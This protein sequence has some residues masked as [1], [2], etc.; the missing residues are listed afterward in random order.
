MAR[1][2]EEARRL[3]AD[4]STDWGTLYELAQTN[5]EV[6]AEIAANPSTYPDLLAWL[7]SLG[8]PDVDAALARRAAGSGDTG[9][10]DEPEP[11]AEPEHQPEPESDLADTAATPVVREPEPESEPEPEPE[12]KPEPELAATVTSPAVREPEPASETQVLP[13]SEEPGAPPAYA[14]A[15]AAAAARVPLTVERVP[16]AQTFGRQPAAPGPGQ[17]PLEPEPPAGEDGS[18]RRL[19]LILVVIGVLA[20]AGIAWLFGR[21]GDEPATTPT[22]TPTVAPTTP[23]PTD[24]GPTSDAQAALDAATA[25]LASVFAASQCT[26]PEADGAALASWAEARLGVGAWDAAAT[27]S[28]TS[29]ITSLQSRCNAGHAVAVADRAG[30]QAPDLAAALGDREWVVPTLPAPADAADITA[31]SSPSGNI[32]C[33]LGEDSVTCS[34]QQYSFGSPGACP[35]PD[36]PV[37]VV[38]DSS[39][40]RADCSLSA[41]TGGP[42]LPY[43]NAARHSHFA[44]T[45]EMDGVTC[46]DTWTGARLKLARA[47]LEIDGPVLGGAG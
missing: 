25:S 28:A 13:S 31:F 26:D 8:K 23:A 5:P 10:Q 21:E 11:E 16:V 9:A 3:A 7:G 38:I 19:V 20:I 12:P 41:V 6:H 22:T 17:P 40:S 37:T 18:R 36:A 32:A 14:P 2:T 39:G 29:A 34:I 4:P 47:V 45:S 43:G 44:C 24:P 27:E 46:W 30:E 15:A 42:S 35:D 33:V 1:G